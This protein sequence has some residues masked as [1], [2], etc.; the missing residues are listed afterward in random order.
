MRILLGSRL[1]L[2]RHGFFNDP[3]VNADIVYIEPSPDDYTFFLMNPMNAWARSQA[4]MHGF[5]SVREAIEDNFDVL[6]DVFRTHGITLSSRR[7]DRNAELL[8][9]AKEDDDAIAEVM[10]SA[11]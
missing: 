2:A 5:L 10:E 4:A 3:D 1:N 6:K 9:A 7:A 11:G 8:A